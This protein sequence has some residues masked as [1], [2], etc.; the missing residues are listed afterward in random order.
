MVNI[1][2]RENPTFADENL[3]SNNTEWSSK[4]LW[5]MISADVKTNIK[6]DNKRFGAYL[7]NIYRKY[8]QK[9]WNTL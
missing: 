4:Y 9:T 5:K 1:S 6:Q 8:L 3:F 2:P 7:T